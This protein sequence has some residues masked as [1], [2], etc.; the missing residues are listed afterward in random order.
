MT[1]SSKVLT[2]VIVLTSVIISTSIYT[3]TLLLKSSD[4]LSGYIVNIENNS[5]NGNW[6]NAKKNLN[7]L[8]EDWHKTHKTWTLLLDHLEIDNIDTSISRM[9]KY[10]ETE[11]I[12]LTL[13]EAAALKQY[14]NHIPEKEVLALKNIF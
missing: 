3:Y 4:R 12:S 5:N 1:Y 13:S 2:L 9:S 6:A 11:N 10:V 8:Q 7:S 14:I